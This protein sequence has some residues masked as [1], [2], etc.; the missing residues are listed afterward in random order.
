MQSSRWSAQF[1]SFPLLCNWNMVR[2]GLITMTDQRSM[3]VANPQCAYFPEHS[4]F[5]NNKDEKQ[6]KHQFSHPLLPPW[7]SQNHRIGD[8]RD[9]INISRFFYYYF[10]FFSFADMWFW[11]KPAVPW[12]SESFNFKKRSPDPCHW[13]FHHWWIS[14]L[15]SAIAKLGSTW[16]RD[17]DTN[18]LQAGGGPRGTS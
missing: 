10:N 1:L 11:S 14:G 16:L 5:M 4:T 17:E 9:I 12:H 8:R 13:A 2:I 7:Y 15:A 3:A 6:E 18:H